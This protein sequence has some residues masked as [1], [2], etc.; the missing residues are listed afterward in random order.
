M[1]IISDKDVPSVESQ[2]L[3]GGPFSRQAPLREAGFT[4]PL[5]LNGDRKKCLNKNNRPISKEITRHAIPMT[6]G[7]AAKEIPQWERLSHVFIVP[8]G[9]IDYSEEWGAK[10]T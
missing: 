10:W 9:R 2:W 3:E 6:L 8:G 4:I 5:I 7:P 1:K